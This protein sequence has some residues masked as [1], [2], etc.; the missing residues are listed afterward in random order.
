[1]N[2]TDLGSRPVDEVVFVRRGLSKGLEYDCAGS[3]IAPQTGLETCQDIRPSFSLTSWLQGEGFASIV[4][5]SDRFCS[6]SVRVTASSGH[7]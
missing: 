4:M 1:M 2:D 3:S 5:S 7:R 6:W